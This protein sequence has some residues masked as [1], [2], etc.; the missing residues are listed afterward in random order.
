MPSD[1][2]RQL[3]RREFARLAAAT[4]VAAGARP[5]VADA[6]RGAAPA[7]LAEFG[8]GDIAVDSRL[9]QAQLQNTHE[10]LMEL[11]EDSLLKPFRQMVGQAAPGADLG[12]WYNYDAD[13]NLSLIHI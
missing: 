3:S 13:Y 11:S 5:L 2:R 9:H 7:A 10:V 12:G 1:H 4:A 8:Y 6:V